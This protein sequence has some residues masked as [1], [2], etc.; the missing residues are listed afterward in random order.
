MS[1]DPEQRRN[2]VTQ[3]WRYLQSKAS[4]KPESTGGLIALY[5]AVVASIAVYYVFR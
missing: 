2:R 5:I 4:G 1:R 3:S